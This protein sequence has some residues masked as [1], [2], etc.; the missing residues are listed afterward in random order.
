MSLVKEVQNVRTAPID[1]TDEPPVRRTWWPLAAWTAAAVLYTLVMH[2]QI[3]LP[4]RYA[5]SNAVVYLCPLALLMIPVSRLTDRLRAR[6]LPA[7]ALIVLHTAIN[8]AAFAIWAFVYVGFL[9]LVIG[10]SMW[11]EVFAGNWIFQLIGAS[12]IYVAA[13]GLTLTAQ[14]YAREQLRERREA[15]LLIVA[16]DAELAA[17]KA[18]LQPHF[19]LN[20]LNSLLVLIDKDPALARMMVT[21]LSDLMKAVFDRF[22][23]VQVPLERELDLIR[24][25]LDI[26]RIRFGSR[27]S[28]VFDVD[29]ASARATVPAFLLQPIVENAVKHGIAPHAKPGAIRISAR[30]IDGRV[31]I[32]VGDSGVAPT[33]DDFA[34]A[35]NMGRGLQLTRRRLDAAYGNRY[36]LSFDRDSHE[37]GLAVRLDLPL[38]AVHAG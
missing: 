8:G 3:R 23:V 25:Y 17:I 2:V 27:L 21:R 15:N 30:M 13:L 37:G 19:V 10:P 11:S 12:S 20:A 1:L 34:S 32:T 38:D 9:R 18:Q 5:A 35:S 22:D 6:H 29:Q 28:V 4:L 33:A 24:A 26:E 31:E 16:R 14:A 36:H 7:G